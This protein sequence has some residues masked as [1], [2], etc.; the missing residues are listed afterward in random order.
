M[1]TLTKLPAAIV[2]T[3]CL[4]SLVQWRNSLWESFLSDSDAPEKSAVPLISNVLP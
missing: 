2:E 1:L 3:G 4:K